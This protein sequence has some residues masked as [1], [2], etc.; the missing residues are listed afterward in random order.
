[1][2]EWGAAVKVREMAQGDLLRAAEFC[3]RARAADPTIEPFG[4]RLGAIA[5][6]PRALFGLWRIAREADASIEGIAFVALREPRSDA[7]VAPGKADLYAAV[8]PEFRRRGLGSELCAPALQWAAREGA[9]LRARVL[10]G[11]LPGQAFLT[12]LGFRQTSAQLLLTWSKPRVGESTNTSVRVKQVAAGEA[13]PQLERL[14]RDAWAD[15][16]DRLATRSDELA[17][18]SREKGRL[19]LIAETGGSAVGYLSGIWMGKTLGIDEIAV[20]PESR[21]KG[22][23]WALLRT[24]VR[25]ATNAVL[26]V[27][28]TNRAALALYRSFGFAQSSRRLVYELPHG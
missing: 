6:G 11:A 13:L 23:G 7:R 25:D 22:I 18:L 3:E 17:Q 16:P 2:N 15:A 24:A 21:R 12:N 19:T 26:S 5:K 14:S 8:A 20:L 4:D 9:T 1:V 28:D 10:D 27:V